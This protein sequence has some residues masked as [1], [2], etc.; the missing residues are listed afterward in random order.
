MR[1]R[2]SLLILA[3]FVLT[4][5][6]DGMNRTKTE[7]EKNNLDLPNPVFVNKLGIRFGISEIFE[8]NAYYSFTAKTDESVSF[9]AHDVSLHLGID[10]YKPEEIQGIKYKEDS[11]N[12]S[13]LD[14]LRDY[15]A[16]KRYSSLESAVVSEPIELF[17]RTGKKGWMQSVEE[18]GNDEMYNLHYLI[19]TIAHKG[20]F[21]VFQ[22]VAGKKNMP[23]LMDDFLEII[24]SV[25]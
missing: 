4:G 10:K 3:S 18:T 22:F 6:P 7:I 9:I 2:L 11:E 5:C 24:K 16:D 1:I 12:L 15:Y 17:S 21:Y 8:E 25:S 19:G 20:N 13:D 14:A 23:Y